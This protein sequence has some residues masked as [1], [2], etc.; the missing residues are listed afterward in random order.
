MAMK[1]IKLQKVRLDE[2]EVLTT[3]Q[4]SS[5]LGG[6]WTTNTSETYVGANGDCWYSCDSYGGDV[7]TEDPILEYGWCNNGS[8]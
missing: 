3:K 2:S 8:R 1:K 4:M 7:C 6:G 5:I